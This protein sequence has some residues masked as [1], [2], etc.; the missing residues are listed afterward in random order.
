MGKQYRKQQQS[1][2]TY[3]ANIL[4]D[5][6]TFTYFVRVYKGRF[7][8]ATLGRSSGWSTRQEAQQQAATWVTNRRLEERASVSYVRTGW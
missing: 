2:T 3:K 1:A 5:P 8:V 4:F 7:L 6:L